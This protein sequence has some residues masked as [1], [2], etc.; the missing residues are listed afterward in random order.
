ML[1]ELNE[2][3]MRLV[4]QAREALDEINKNTDESRAAELEQRH[5]AIMAEYDDTEGRI[6]REERM[7]KIE[8]RAEELRAERRPINKGGEERGGDD[9]PS[10]RNVFAK[11]VCGAEIGELSAEERAVLR[12]GST[13]FEQRAQTAGTTTAGGYT[14]PTELANEIVRSMLAWGPMYDENVARVLTTASGNPMKL[15]TVNDTAVTAEAHTEAAALTDDGGKDVTFGQ[16]SLD[17]YVFDTEFVRWSFELDDDSIFSME[18][19]LADLLGERLGRI[20][21]AQ[22]TTGTGSSAPNGVVTAST[23]GKT[24]AGVAAITADELMDLEHSVNRAYRKSPKAAFMMNDL[25]LKAVRKL[26]DSENR[27][28]WQAPDIRSSYPQSLLGYNLHINDS[29]ADLAT[30]AKTVLFGDFNK[31]FVRKVGAPVIGVLRE[32]FWPDLGI[33]GLI[34]FDG[35]LG[36]TA[37][38]KHLI[39]A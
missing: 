4:A 34:R 9:A 3:R 2:K 25:T 16:K 10:Y 37:A 12:Q 13:K 26:K 27:Y 38:V 28:I 11:V 35:E 24:A 17:A 1:N 33:A 5:D 19:L 6:A 15:P 22:L 20:A 8:A 7:S 31:Y 36:D 39:Q 18:A 30:G 21:N 23:L 29:M 14:V 32:R